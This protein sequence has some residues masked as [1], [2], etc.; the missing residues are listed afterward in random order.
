MTLALTPHRQRK[1]MPTNLVNLD[2]LIPREDF[3][4]EINASPFDQKDT[5]SIT[6][7]QPGFFYSALRKPDFQRETASWP[8]LKIA[9]LVASFLNGDLIPALILWQP[10]AKGGSIFVID[11]AHR[12]GA[13]I[14][15]VRNDYGDDAISRKFF[16]NDIPPEQV[17]AAEKTRK[18]VNEAVGSYEEH[19]A[20]TSFPGNTR[21]E[22]IERSKRLGSLAV[23]VQWV[24]GNADKAEASFFKINQAATPID[25]TELVILE[26]RNTPSAISARAIIRAGAGHKYWERFL[27]E[28]QKLIETTASEIYKNLFSPPLTT[29]IKTLDLPVAGRAY[30]AQTLP[31]IFDFVNL[32]NDQI[33]ISK[34]KYQT[35]RAKKRKD[36]KEEKP[37]DLDGQKTVEYMTKV[38]KMAYRISGVH[39]SSLGLHPAIY[40][41]SS[42]GRHQPPAFLAVAGFV[43]GL[44][45]RERLNQFTK[46]RE[47]FEDFL[48]A[49]KEFVNQIVSRFGGG[50]KSYDRLK[51]MYHMILDALI[52]ERGEGQILLDFET[53]PEL[54]FLKVTPA[55]NDDIVTA[56]NFSAS[57]KSAVFMRD[58]LAQPRERCG[59][60]NARLHVNSIHIDHIQRKADGGMGTPENA[61]LSHPYCNSTYKH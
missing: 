40:F 3:E 29:P 4:V 39:P 60:C 15:W 10:P 38:K 35:A 16:Q 54:R 51:E 53:H 12:L 24:N 49:H 36:K 52:M 20:A 13:L 42:T 11:G 18:L 1:A 46:Y 47:K 21:P 28:T 37:K 33:L 59:I 43:K 48:L 30:S 19:L 57:T 31:L 56:V 41:Y 7:L 58:A 55:N 34:E 6:D 5:I 61:Q 23:R 50:F 9:D 22:V 25:P 44:V 27:P 26:S 2:A 32:V 8:P 17:R 14:A 45:E